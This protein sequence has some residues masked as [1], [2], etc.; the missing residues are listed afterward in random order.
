MDKTYSLMVVDGAY[1]V[2]GARDISQKTNRK[3]ILTE[4]KLKLIDEY[5]Q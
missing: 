5:I 4:E 1:V 2:L 3:L